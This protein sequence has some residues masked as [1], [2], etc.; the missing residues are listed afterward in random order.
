MQ[1]LVQLPTS[2]TESVRHLSQL[3]NTVNES[4]NTFTSLERPVTKW[5]DILVYFIESK[6]AVTTRLDWVKE[7]E[8]RKLDFPKYSDLQ[9]FLEDRIRTLDLVEADS[10]KN[11]KH[12]ESKAQS[13]GFSSQSGGEGRRP[14]FYKKTKGV[15]VHMASRNQGKPRTQCS[16][17][18]GDHFL[19]YCQ[20]FVAARLCT[21]SR[22]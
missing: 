1:T 2:S 6:L 13:S 14:Q 10:F 7:V 11:T 3:L 5:D 12:E 4:V 20:K 19:G 18:N 21:R 8:R 16:F 15:S 17:C 9:T 22:E